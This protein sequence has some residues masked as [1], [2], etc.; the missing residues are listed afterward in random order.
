MEELR[1]RLDSG[2]PTANGDG[3][4]C[5][6]ASYAVS[7]VRSLV[8]GRSSGTGRSV[9]LTRFYEVPATSRVPLL[10]DSQAAPGNREPVEQTR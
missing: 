7:D 2:W 10:E 8:P 5:V 6:V 3:G 4:V 9:F 1:S